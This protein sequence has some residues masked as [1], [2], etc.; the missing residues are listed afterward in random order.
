MTAAFH[1]AAGTLQISMKTAVLAI[2]RGGRK[3]ACR[4]TSGLHD[5]HY[6]DSKAGIA[7]TMRRAWT[8]YDGLVCIMAAGIVVRSIAQ[9]LENKQTD[10]CVIVCDESGRFV[11]SLLSGHIGGG[12]AL[13]EKISGLIGGQ[14]VITTASDILGHTAVD[15]WARNHC[16]RAEDDG[17]FVRLSSL[18]L[19]SGRLRVLSDIEFADMPEDFIL[20]DDARNA[21]LIVSA[22]TGFQGLSAQF[23]RPRNLVVG[24]GCNRGTTC[25][26][27]QEA[28]I[29]TLTMHKLSIFSI[30]ALASID[31]KADEQGLLKFAE[32]KNLELQLYSRDEL[33]SVPG[34]KSSRTVYQ[35]IGAHGVAEPAAILASNGGRLRVEKVKWPDVTIAI[36][37]SSPQRPVTCSSSV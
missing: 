22:R 36:A 2:T 16:L 13:A 25:R 23:L 34:L 12:N 15:I 7:E 35:A 1:M 29:G 6:L 18:L 21:D 27:I 10:P 9:L 31:L 3:L 11:I 14:A 26:R 5:C 8:E 17:V 30:R 37:V 28:L 19:D 20:V 4:I 32:T 24:I 33:N